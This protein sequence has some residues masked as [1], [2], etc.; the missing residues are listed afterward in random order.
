MFIIYV[1]I[2]LVISALK[3]GGVGGGSKGSSLFGSPEDYDPAPPKGDVDIP[4]EEPLDIAK[5]IDDWADRLEDTLGGIFTDEKTDEDKGEEPFSWRA[6][7]DEEE[8]PVYTP[9]AAAWAEDHD[10]IPSTALSKE[11]RLEQLERLK[12]AGLLDDEEYKQ[13]KREIK[14]G[15]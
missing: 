8:T 4:P 7:V 14:R 5:T 15:G 3:K 12:E 1:V 2:G 10:H 11:K 6:K 9:T 13:K